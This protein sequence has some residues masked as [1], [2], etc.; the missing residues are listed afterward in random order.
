MLT[1]TQ[2]EAIG[3]LTVAFSLVEHVIEVC[4]ADIVGTSEFSVGIVIAEEDQFARKV[5]RLKRILAAILVERKQVKRHVD[6]VVM[7]LDEAKKLAVHRNDFVHGVVV[8]DVGKDEPRIQSKKRRRPCDETEIRALT[9]Q[10]EKTRQAL[11]LAFDALMHYF[12]RVRK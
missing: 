12:D 3:E 9:K 10:A 6:R 7:L 1:R 4:F 11:F 8:Y 2:Y 5:E